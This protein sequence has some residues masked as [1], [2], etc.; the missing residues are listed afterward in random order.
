MSAQPLLRV[1]SGEDVETPVEA[2]RRFRIREVMREVTLPRLVRQNR[3]PGTIAKYWK[4]V[5]YWE[6]VSDDPPVEQITAEQIDAFPAELLNPERRLGLTTATSA[7]QQQM[8]IEAILRTVGPRIG[9]HGGNGALAAVPFGQRLPRDSRPR[10]RFIRDDELWNRIYAAS[11]VATW[12]DAKVTGL[13][14]PLLWRAVWSLF[15]CCAP[16]R[17]ELFLLPP[18]CEWDRGTLVPTVYQQPEHPDGESDVVSPHGWCVYHTPKT[19]RRKGGWPL[20]IP[21]SSVARRHLDAVTRM[22]RPTIFCMGESNSS[23]TTWRT[24][25]HKIQAA[26]G[27]DEPFGFHDLRRSVNRLYRK[28]A[29]REVAKFILGQQPRGVNAES[30]DDLTEDAVDAVNALPWPEEFV[31]GAAELQT[32]AAS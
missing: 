20:V 14:A 28:I 3:A 18:R 32:A 29:G 7:N 23:A 10:K 12:P 26:A 2:M 9:R 5:E 1:Y 15:F 17:S 22:T 16:R 4:A 13:P 31:R 24:W 30:Y 27:I 21:L 6:L 8:Y 25:S 11:R 19:R